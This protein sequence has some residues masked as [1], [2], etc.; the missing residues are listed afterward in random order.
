MHIFLAAAGFLL[1]RPGETDSFLPLFKKMCVVS[2]AG[3]K[4]GFNSE[5]LCGR[6]PFRNGRG[7]FLTAQQERLRTAGRSK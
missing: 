4:T 3:C 2:R 5:W 7:I 6:A 1:D